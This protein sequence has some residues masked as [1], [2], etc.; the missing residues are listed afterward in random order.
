[1]DQH[2]IP[3]QISS[4]EFRLIGDMTLKQFA[5]LGAGVLV[6]LLLYASPL[7]SYIKW[8]LVLTFTS[9]GIFSAFVPIQERPLQTWIFAFIKA[10]YSPT[11][12]SWR[13]NTPLPEIFEEKAAVNIPLQ[14]KSIVPLKDET[15]LSEYLATLTPAKN[16]L[17]KK[18]EESLARIKQL[19]RSF[20]PLKT[21]S[22]SVAAQPAFTVTATPQ[23]TSQREEVK[24]FR[25]IIPIETPKTE[26]PT[27]QKNYRPPVLNTQ[28]TRTSSNLQNVQFGNI[29][30]P[31][32]PE[33][34]NILVGMVF[35]NEGRIVEGA[36][37]E[38]H[39]SGGNPVRALRTNKLGQFRIATPLA[40]GHYEM[41]IEK[42]GLVFDK[43]K[44]TLD[45]E[46]IKPIEIKAKNVLN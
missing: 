43:F 25:P 6:A 15:K 29:P 32:V 1:M 8:P 21:P 33:I 4:Y 46:I 3:Q 39:D 18:E 24:T 22:F 20:S 26:T 7:P 42:E 30:M 16:N 34:P 10:V 23:T 40:N 5:Q 12:Y 45:G 28:L 36:I 17:D 11:Q 9:L 38:I 44:I 2:L 13:K 31:S 14:F 37:L 41:E 19:F 27:V 35:S